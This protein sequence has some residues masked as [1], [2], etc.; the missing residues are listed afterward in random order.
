V[1]AVASDLGELLWIEAR[2]A[3]EKPVNVGSAMIAAMLLDFT[4]PP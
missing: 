3:H 2:A 1:V 4:E